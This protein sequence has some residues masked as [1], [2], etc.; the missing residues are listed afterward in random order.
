MSWNIIDES[1][2][3]LKHGRNLEAGA[4]AQ[5]M[6]KSCLEVCSS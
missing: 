4:D 6:E 5:A 1:G 2:Q 3:G